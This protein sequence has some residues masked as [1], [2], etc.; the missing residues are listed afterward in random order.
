LYLDHVAL[1]TRD[2]SG[3]LGA[4]LGQLGGTLVSGG[5]WI[6]FQSLQVH[7]GD[8]DRGMKLE[9]LEPWEI[10]A[11]DFLERFLA[12]HGDAPHHL[13][14]KVDDLDATLERVKSAG[15]TPVAVDVSHPEWMEA[16][17]QPR[18]AHGTVVQLAQSDSPLHSPLEEYA[19]AMKQGPIEEPRWWPEP[20]ARTDEVASLRRV[21]MATPSPD[22][23]LEFFGGLLDG[24][25]A[26]RGPGWI[27]L[28]W[29]GGGRVRL[30]ERT[31]RAP[32]ID[33]L[34]LAAPGARREL[35]IAGTRFV[36]NP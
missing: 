35:D 10:A 15:Y 18:E 33:R 19:Q 31:D 11:N 3:Q 30:E 14:F 29:S 28:G 6:G 21:V 36:V 23:A 4:L 8:A 2:A 16:F 12:K 27:E 9:L 17:L 1:G 22:A 7:L 25:D 5:R 24:T 20:P 13:T 34:E 32:G 26:D